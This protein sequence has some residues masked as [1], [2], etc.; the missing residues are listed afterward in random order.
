MLLYHPM[1]DLSHYIFR[2]LQILVATKQQEI[3]V[4]QIRILDFYLLFP[5]QIRYMQ[6]PISA[7]GLKRRLSTN[8]N[9]YDEIHDPIL[10]FARMEPYQLLA[11]K[12]L[13]SKDMITMDSIK[14][15]KVVLQEENLPYE[16]KKS[17]ENKNEKEHELMEFLTETLLE[18]EFFGDKGLKARTKLLEYR[19]DHS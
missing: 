18:L 2:I 8:P 4:E 9:P 7:V 11:L 3:Y 10:I 19:Y 6:V 12:C 5:S 17:V 1:Y 16:L 13:V 15:G 14:N